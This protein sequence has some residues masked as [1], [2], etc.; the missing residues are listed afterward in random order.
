M[1][2]LKFDMALNVLQPSKYFSMIFKSILDCQKV[3]D[4]FTEVL[5]VL[6]YLASFKIFF[7]DF[8]KYPGLPEGPR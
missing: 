6:E 4:D 1:T 5:Q 3:Q 8:Y 2:F 7:Y